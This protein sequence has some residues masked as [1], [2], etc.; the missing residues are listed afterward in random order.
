VAGRAVGKQ[1]E[2]GAGGPEGRPGISPYRAAPDDPVEIAIGIALD[3]VD[4]LQCVT[5]E[6]AKR[7]NKDP[8][9]LRAAGRVTSQSSPEDRREAAR[10]LTDIARLQGTLSSMIIG[11]GK[12]NPT[13]TIDTGIAGIVFA[14]GGMERYWLIPMVT[15]RVRPVDGTPIKMGDGVPKTASCAKG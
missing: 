3:S 14:D 8:A 1:V 15:T 11:K 2:G 13:D 5:D 9:S 6:G 12:I 4:D 10:L 7:L